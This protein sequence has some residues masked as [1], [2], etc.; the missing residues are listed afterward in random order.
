LKLEPTF[1]LLALLGCLILKG[2]YSSVRASL[3][4]L[5]E[6]QLS[7]LH[8]G[9][10]SRIL[11]ALLSRPRRTSTSLLLVE[12]ACVAGL[13]VSAWLAWE[14]WGGETIWIPTAIAVTLLAIG[15]PLLRW[16]SLVLAPQLH[17]GLIAW[18]AWLAD[19]LLSPLSR[20]MD[21]MGRWLASR[22]N[23]PTG[24]KALEREVIGLVER[25]R[26]Q[27]AI[28][29][30]EHR[31][32]HRVLEFGGRKVAKVMTPRADMFSLPVTMKLEEAMAR[33]RESGYSRVPVY[34]KT[35]DDILGILFAKDMLKFLTTA[36]KEEIS[37]EKLLRPPYFVSMTME[38]G[39]L[40]RELRRRKLHMALCVD[41][42]G[43]VAGLVT[44][45]DILEELFGEIYD[46]YDLEIRWWEQG[47]EDEY[48]VSG[49]LPLHKLE[50]I[51][52]VKLAQSECH[53]V[54]GLVLERLGRF[55]SVGD[56]VRVGELL[57][58]VEK[59]TPTRIQLVRVKREK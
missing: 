36:H 22:G 29:K 43:G 18:S 11:K 56:R 31:I 30:E 39:E 24:D 53:T 42:F 8:P 35:K 33:V 49:K 54:A 13:G 55:P 52:G 51:T 41:E 15:R 16:R 26:H 7:R 17:V 48:I 21:A 10:S 34:G 32:I 45:E 47:G 12:K 44:M 27:G 20:S 9:L 2:F 4:S 59:V 1:H 28:E 50:E 14:A 37:V 58:E 19:L 46:E 23:P 5:K 25:G 6:D 3:F 38:A 40:L 57:L